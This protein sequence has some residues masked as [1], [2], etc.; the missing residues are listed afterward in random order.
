MTFNNLDGEGAKTIRTEGRRPKGLEVSRLVW[1][2]FY[3]HLAVF[4]RT[5]PANIMFG[6]IEPLLYL[7]ALGIGLGAYVQEVPGQSYLEFIAPGLIASSAM[8]ATAS[9]D[10]YDAFLRLHYQKIYQSIMATP[11][12]LDE[13]VVAEILYGTFKSV[14]YG[15][16]ILAVVTLLGLVKSPLAL[17]ILLALVLCGLIFAELALTWTSLTPSMDTFNYF[18]TLVVTPMFLFSGIFFPVQGLPPAV[19]KL[20]WFIPLYHVVEINRALAQ[21]QPDGIWVNAI[22]LVV[23]AAALLPL[24]VLLMRRRLLQ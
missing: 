22:W 14:L 1:P 23:V 20:A 18:F 8:W 10:T 15:G 17:G 13:I 6:F 12:S 11:V 5:W 24:P 4:A 9:E 21:G 2:V 3:R 19:Q 7:A 16:I